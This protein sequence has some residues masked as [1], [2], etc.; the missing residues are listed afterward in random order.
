M[1][2]SV[3]LAVTDRSITRKLVTD[4]TAGRAVARRFVAGDTLDEAVAVS[5][6][7]NAM[8]MSVSLDHL[9]EHVAVVE[10]TIA[11]RDSY[12]ACLS[13]I[14]NQGLDANISVK[15][16][17]LGMG[18]DDETAARHLD[19]I[20]AAA[21]EAGTTV[22]IDMEDSGHTQ[23]TIDLYV[24][25]QKRHGN[26]G[27]AVQSY[28]RRT[29]EDLERIIP[30]G[31]HIRLCKGAYA[32]PSEVAYQSGDEVD[33]SFDRLG[34]LLMESPNVIPAIA[35][36]DDQRQ[37]KTIDA[38]ARREEPWEFQM[39]Y[40]VQRD[41]QAELVSMGHEVRVYVPYGEAWYP[42]LTRRLAEKPAN[43]FFFLRA[44]VKD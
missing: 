8:G 7:L 26:I 6:E 37:V 1:M 14:A 39:L 33:A 42:Y 4:T 2:R 11:A 13:R 44:L 34:V 41:R 22:T 5:K 43:L 19:E 25:A 40:G 23:A 16:T 24:A 17:Q 10:E 38:A 12:L 32:E 31:G 29:P 18:M 36:H 15:L 35:T 28:L 27:V 20:A 3:L 9:G 21:L 30:I